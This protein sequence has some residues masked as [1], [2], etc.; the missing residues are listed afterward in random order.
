MNQK[1]NPYNKSHDT[2]PIPVL[3]LPIGQLLQISICVAPDTFE[4]LPEK[5]IAT[6][7]VKPFK[8]LYLPGSQFIH[9]IPYKTFTRG[10]SI[11]ILMC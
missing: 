3:Y 6:G 11:Y 9:S 10:H 2:K 1:D 7:L 4:Y 5:M 8:S